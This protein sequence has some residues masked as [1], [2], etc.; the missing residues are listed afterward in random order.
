MKARKE[1]REKLKKVR[2]HGSEFSNFPKKYRT[3]SLPRMV[4]DWWGVRTK[5]EGAAA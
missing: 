2:T 5:E 3:K 1:L 4:R